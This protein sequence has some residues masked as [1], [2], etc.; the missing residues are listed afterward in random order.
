MY[1]KHNFTYVEPT[2][3]SDAARFNDWVEA[4]K[5]E[6]DAIEKNKTWALIEL[7]KDKKAIG[8]KWGFYNQI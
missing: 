4:M 1:E 7:P 2:S 5:V 6:I 8:V 3:Y